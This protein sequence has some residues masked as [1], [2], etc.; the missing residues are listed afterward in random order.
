MH[1][2]KSHTQ[3]VNNIKGL[4]PKSGESSWTLAVFSPPSR[5]LCNYTPFN[6][7]VT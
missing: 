7:G 1:K 2:D 3:G 6:L 5:S 4:E